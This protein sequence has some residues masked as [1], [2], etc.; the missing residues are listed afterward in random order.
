MFGESKEPQVKKIVTSFFLAAILVSCGLMDIYYNKY[1][2]FGA[3]EISYGESYEKVIASNG[4][5][6]FVERESYEKALHASARVP[7]SIPVFNEHG[8]IVGSF[9][10]G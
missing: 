2:F 4:K 3:R 6:G 5:K 10:V 1:P 7:T 9:I 8:K